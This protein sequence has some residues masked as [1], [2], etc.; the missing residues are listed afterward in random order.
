MPP[1]PIQP[2]AAAHKNIIANNQ[3]NGAPSPDNRT[4]DAIL[5]MASAVQSLVERF[6]SMEVRM[7][8]I[9]QQNN[10]YTVNPAMPM[11][12]DNMPT[13]QNRPGPANQR[14]HTNASQIRATAQ[15][16]VITI[17]SDG[18]DHPPNGNQV[19]ADIHR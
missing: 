5:V 13:H 6:G 10:T 3:N 2:R 9:E 4:R 15:P 7:N 1:L 8:S 19:Q 14:P 16:Q 17:D 18:E 12:I 11:R